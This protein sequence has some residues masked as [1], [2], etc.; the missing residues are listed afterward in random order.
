MRRERAVRI[1][2][3]LIAALVLICV[4][5]GI[6][7]ARRK[8][9]DTAIPVTVRREPVSFVSIPE[10]RSGLVCRDALLSG[11]ILFYEDG[12]LWE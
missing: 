7:F 1:R 11:H 3:A 8:R 2:I 12:Y 6:L 10:A 9:D 4:L 5:A